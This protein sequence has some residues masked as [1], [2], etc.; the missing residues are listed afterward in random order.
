MVLLTMTATIVEA[1]EKIQGCRSTTERNIQPGDDNALPE[2]SDDN[3]G[4]EDQ[5]Q[6]NAEYD[7][8][9][10]GESEKKKSAD[11]PKSADSKERTKGNTISEPTLS[12]P[13]IGSP[14]SHGQVVDLS[15]AMKAQMLRPCRLEDLLKGARLYIPPPPP[16]PEPVRSHPR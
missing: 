1:L 16:K 12:N 5:R 11:T 8:G 14:I 15:Q 4:R 2:R 6:E 7:S 13:R 3:E 9:E 10:S